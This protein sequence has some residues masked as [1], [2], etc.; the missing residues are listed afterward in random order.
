[1]QAILISIPKTRHRER[2][3][4]GTAAGHS[5]KEY[6]LDANEACA[7]GRSIS[8][9]PPGSRCVLMNPELMSRWAGKV[10]RQQLAKPRRQNSPK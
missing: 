10:A 7:K 3:M 6:A 9:N 4:Q 8:P 2:E 5:E 1:M